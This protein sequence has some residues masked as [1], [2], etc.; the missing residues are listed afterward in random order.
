VV[1]KQ[2]LGLGVFGVVPTIRG[3][4][5]YLSSSPLK[6]SAANVLDRYDTLLII[7]IIKSLII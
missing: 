7:C 5:E 6:L 1:I 4:K 3:R 2:F